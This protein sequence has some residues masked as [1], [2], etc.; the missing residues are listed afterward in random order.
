MLGQSGRRKGFHL[1]FRRCNPDFWSGNLTA[2]DVH[3]QRRPQ[4][5]DENGDSRQTNPFFSPRSISYRWAPFSTSLYFGLA[6]PQ[7]CQCW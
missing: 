7:I 2:D 6:R 1:K 5:A 3:E 4:C